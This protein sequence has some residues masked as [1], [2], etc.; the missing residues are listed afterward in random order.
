[1]NFRQPG[2]RR[3]R[4]R[5]DQLPSR[6]PRPRAARYG[7]AVIVRD[8]KREAKATILNGPTKKHG[9]YTVVCEAPGTTHT[10]QLVVLDA[11]KDAAEDERRG[12]LNRREIVR[13]DPGGERPQFQAWE[14][15]RGVVVARPDGQF[16]LR[17]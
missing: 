11:P 6:Q 17:R 3:V 16:V 10:W 9:L 15:K 12:T 1:M 8:G 14:A 2:T 7:E 5:L 13:S 4:V